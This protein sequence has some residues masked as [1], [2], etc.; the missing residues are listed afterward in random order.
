MHLDVDV[1]VGVDVVTGV[2]SR[3]ETMDMYVGEM[4]L[5]VPVDVV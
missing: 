2:G 3:V 1:T 4:M 5:A